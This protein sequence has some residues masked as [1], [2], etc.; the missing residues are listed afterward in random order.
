MIWDKEEGKREEK[1][2]TEGAMEWRD[3][4]GEKGTGTGGETVSYMRSSTPS[5]FDTYTRL[6]PISVRRS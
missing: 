3:R 5:R 1:G 6:V 4:R 2:E